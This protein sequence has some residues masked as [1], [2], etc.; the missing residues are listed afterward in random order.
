MVCFLLTW[1]YPQPAENPP[2]I[3]TVRILETEREKK[4]LAPAPIESKPKIVPK[5]KKRKPDPPKIVIAK[6]A[7]NPSPLSP[8]V[9][10]PA[11][12]EVT[13]SFEEK[14]IEEPPEERQKQEAKPA[15]LGVPEGRKDMDIASLGNGGASP[16]LIEESGSAEKGIPGGLPLAVF[17]GEGAGKEGVGQGSGIGEKGSIPSQGVKM[18]SVFFHGEGERKGKRDLSSYLGSARLKIERAK[19]YPREARRRGWEG[20]V[21][22]SFQ[23]NQNGEVGKIDIVQS[24]SY[25]ELDEEG[26]STIRRAAPFLPPPLEDRDTLEIRVPLVFKLE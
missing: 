24:S 8:P 4:P 19:R 26:V 20:K 12:H 5:Q 13:Q 23:I 9:A 17:A 14:K 21:V 16:G 7:E 11:I 25:R 3:V 18:G 15:P 10:E 1:S 6:E 22:L 2:K